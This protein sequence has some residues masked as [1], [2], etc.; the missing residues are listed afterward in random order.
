M[1]FIKKDGSAK[2]LKEF[3]LRKY[4][5]TQNTA[6]RQISVGQTI[7]FIGFVD[8][9]ENIKSNSKWFKTED[10]N[11]FWSG[12]V[13][14]V[15]D[16]PPATEDY[17]PI[18]ATQLCAIISCT[19]TKANELI[20]PLNQA[21]LEFSINT[22]LRQA[23]FIAQTAHESIGYTAFRENLNYSAD[24]LVRTW[25]RRFT[26]KTAQSYA[27]QPE[28]IAN[29]VYANRIGNGGETS[30]D[31]WRYRGRGI[32]QVTGKNNYKACGTGL[33]LDLISSPELLEQLTHAFR[34][35][36]WFW[37]SRN[38]SSL[39][40]KRDFLGITKIINGGINGQ[41]DRERYYV[42]AKTAIGIA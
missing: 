29:C 35:G 42:R 36:A 38:L 19:P 11:Y 6:V 16:Q 41:E 26:P 10:G 24:A 8:D 40:D 4:P 12:N 5:S 13:E 28:K 3:N 9:G 31:G 32:I 33:G 21:M 2:A 1:N 20:G 25:P 7:K 23:A 37:K 14:A 27:R 18:T 22:P 15:P 39:A 30:G 34:S 17:Q